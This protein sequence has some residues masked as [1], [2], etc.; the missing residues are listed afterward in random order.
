ML[1]MSW[2]VWAPVVVTAPPP[3][4]TMPPAS[5]VRLVKAEPALAAPTA[6]PKVVAP[7]VR[8]SKL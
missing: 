5:V 6:P 8:I 2:K 3:R 1:T 4:S 7:V